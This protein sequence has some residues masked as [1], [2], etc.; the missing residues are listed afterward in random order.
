MVKDWTFP[1]NPFMFINI[2]ERRVGRY[3]VSLADF[4]KKQIQRNQEDFVSR[5]SDSDIQHNLTSDCQLLKTNII[6]L[7]SNAG[8]AVKLHPLRQNKI[9]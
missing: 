4:Q 5:I 6:F 7:S 3:L 9:I 2:F 1:Y 8:Y